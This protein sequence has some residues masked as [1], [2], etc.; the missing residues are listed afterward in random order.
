M[1]LIAAQTVAI[2]RASQNTT[3]RPGQEAALRAGR[4]TASRPGWRIEKYL[5]IEIL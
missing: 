5:D 3:S 4:C 2:S 1:V